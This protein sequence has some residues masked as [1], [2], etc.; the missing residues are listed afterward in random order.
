MEVIHD[1]RLRR[2]EYRHPVIVP[3]NHTL[4]EFF[5]PK[6]F[7]KHAIL[8]FQILEKVTLRGLTVEGADEEDIRL[9]QKVL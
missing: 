6:A 5:L 3:S 2:Y 7:T 8:D 9:I 4:L 1:C